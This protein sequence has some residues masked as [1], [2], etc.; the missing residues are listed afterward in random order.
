MFQVKTIDKLSAYQD[1][2]IKKLLEKS[3]DKPIEDFFRKPGKNIRSRL[4]EIGYRMSHKV[5][6]V[7]LDNEVRKKIKSAGEIV[8]L[9]HAGSLI[10]DDIQDGS[11]IRRDGPTLH[12]QH[13]M[14]LALNA[15]NYLY[16]QGLSKLREL[17]ATEKDYMALTEDLLKLMVRAHQGQ[18][19]DLGTTISEIKQIEVKP[20]CLTSMELK[21]GTLMALAL[22][23]GSGIKGESNLESMLTFGNDLGLLLQ[24]Y[25]D[26][27]NFHQDPTTRN[28][29][30]L[31][32]LKL[33]RPTWIWAVA[34]DL[35]SAIYDD[36]NKAVSALP[37]KAALD[38]WIVDHDF[39][40][41]LKTSTL[42]FSGEI[43]SRWQKQ[44]SESHP[45]TIEILKELVNK[46]E[47]SYVR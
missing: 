37:D 1:E 24:M 46:L 17:V 43:M 25:D 20:T 23:L 33:R 40:N 19:L 36:F 4:V 44:F 21:T 38:S 7:M 47:T 16:F 29:K 9:I 34:S 45:V 41:M 15:G 12:L 26:F 30:F 28:D 5:E 32:D 14:P 31:E 3:L 13:G 10:V 6:P 2:V 11:T 42:S 39:I 35:D 27:G 18:A 22:R 8:E